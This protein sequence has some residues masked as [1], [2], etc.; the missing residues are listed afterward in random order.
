M[1]SQRF[2]SH[3]KLLLTGE[4]LVL[5]GAEALAI[6]C[7]FGQYLEVTSSEEEYSTWISYDYENRVW[8]DLKFDLQK[9]LNQR[10]EGK[11]DFEKRLFQILIEAN[12]L[13]SKVFYQNYNFETRLEFPRNWGLGTSSTLIANVSKW[14]GINPYQ[15]L[16]KTFGGSG[17]DIACAE[18]EFPLVYSLENKK[19]KVKKAEIP[20][21][22][23][24]YLYYVY[25]EEKQNSREA[26]ANYRKVKPRNL[27]TLISKISNIT[28]EFQSIESYKYAQQLLHSHEECL[29]QILKIEPIQY[30][31][32]PDFDGAIKSLGAWGGDF[33]M[34][35]CET[36]PS[37]Y[38]KNKGYNTILSYDEMSL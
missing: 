26:I 19:Q 21:A 10:R 29:S 17:Y 13:N 34:V 38:F 27:E 15:L 35:I 28:Q 6:P 37:S 2:Y 25:L 30:Q 20:E 24:P 1:E 31:L 23:K 22:L 4:Y 18:S 11:N 16:E 14:A 8:L 32:F 12:R 5:D 3:G 9:V 33:I 36:N 7:K